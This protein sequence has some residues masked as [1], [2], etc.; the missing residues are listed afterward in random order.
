MC[1]SISSAGHDVSLLVPTEK[2]CVVDGVAI[3]AV[4]M[5][6]SKLARAIETPWFLYRRALEENADVYQFHDPELIPIGLLLRCIHKRKIIYDIHEHVPQQILIRSYIPKWLRKW[7]AAGFDMFERH[8]ASQFS[9][10]V[11]ANE[12]INERFKNLRGPVISIHNYAEVEEFGPAAI[13][14]P[15]RYA[16]SIVY[17]SCGNERTAFPA[18]LQALELVSRNVQLRAI[19][20]EPTP[21]DYD[22]A[23]RQLE[24]ARTDRV[25]LRGVLPRKDMA[26]IMSSCAVSMVLYTDARN[27]SSIR[28]NRF[29]ESLA[30]GAPVIVSDFPEW[31]AAVD[32]IG[33]GLSVNPTDPASIAA[34]IEYICTHHSEAAMMGECGRK[35]FLRSFNWVPEKNKL[36]Q[37]YDTLVAPNNQQDQIV[38][39]GT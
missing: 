21:A 17:H 32:S 22:A 31:Q 27:H 34:A 19:V 28:S 9:A 14:D 35:A 10:L 1:R 30:A 33:C 6:R 26:D 25:E 3:R 24:R 36:L 2:D 12:D 8:S 20:T 16:S 38:R 39:T 4:P 23:A 18:V 11:T 15:S 13:L 29:Y 7:V 37:L 5:P